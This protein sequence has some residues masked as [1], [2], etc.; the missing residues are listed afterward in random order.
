MNRLSGVLF[1]AV[2]LSQIVP[3]RAADASGVVSSE[4]F[5]EAKEA[6][7]AAGTAQGYALACEAGLV[8]GSYFEQSGARVRTLH[9]AIE[10][11]AQAITSGGAG[12]GP[13]VNYAIGFGFEAKRLHSVGAASDSKKLFMEAVALFPD[14]G[15]AH[16]A[17]AGWHSNVTRQAGLG[18]IAL[19]ASRQDARR[20]FDIAIGLDPEN[21]AVR[22]EQLRFLVA[23]DRKDRRAAL[24]AAAAMS[25]MTPRTAFDAFVLA[26]T[27]ALAAALSGSEKDIDAALASTEPFAGVRGEAP[28][29][30]FAPPFRT[31][32]PAAAGRSE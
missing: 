25:T 4:V 11:C 9:R 23:G 24:D 3:A 27:P 10:D 16:A 6:G 12:V 5:A 29:T 19:G 21:L 13:Y 8:L 22:F 32:F 1:A 14:S 20:H 15:F 18:R 30:R 26:Q 17:L 28:D 2:C 31:Q 7:R